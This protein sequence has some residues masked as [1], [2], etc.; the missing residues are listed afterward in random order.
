MNTMV[1]STAKAQM[2]T[3]RLI[4]DCEERE[5]AD[6]KMAMSVGGC[7]FRRG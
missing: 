5:K 7:N 3:L 2:G 4:V 6:G 1:Q